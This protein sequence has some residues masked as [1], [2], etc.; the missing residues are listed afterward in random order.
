MLLTN[1]SASELL[2]TGSLF[3]VP[4]GKWHQLTAAD[5]VTILYISPA[6]DGATRQ[7]EHPYAGEPT[8]G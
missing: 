2:R 4:R 1:H 3:V 6:E 7:R 8:P 5:Y